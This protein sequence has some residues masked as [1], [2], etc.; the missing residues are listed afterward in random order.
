MI[1]DLP[2]CETKGITIINEF[3]IIEDQ[4]LKIKFPYSFKRAMYTLVYIMKGKHKCFYCSKDILNGKVTL[5]HIFPQDFGGPTI[6]NNL[7]PSCYKCN[8]EKSNMTPDQYQKFLSLPN[9]QR[10]EYL[11]D[12]QGIFE[13]IRK[14][15]DFVLPEGWVQEQQISNIIT[16][17]SLSE[18]YKNR[19]YTSIK[20]F[21]KKYNHFQHPLIIDRKNF[22]LDGFLQLMYAKN[23]NIEILPV[24]ILENVEVVF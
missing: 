7:Q 5:D 2:K 15:S 1:I 3:M 14:W 23:Y 11:K 10:K 21:Y 19:K 18:D 22:L 6:P 12:L 9:M 20:E 16:S 4:I 13:F 17:I 24:I 8:N